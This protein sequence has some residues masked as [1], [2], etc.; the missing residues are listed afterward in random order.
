MSLNSFKDLENIQKHSILF[1][2]IEKH[3]KNIQMFK[4]CW[5]A[6]L[7]LQKVDILS[8]NA[9]IIL[10]SFL[11]LVYPLQRTNVPVRDSHSFS[12]YPSTIR[13]SSSNSGRWLREV[14]I[15]Y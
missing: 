15:V 10:V 12:I 4:I 7:G 11:Q 9:S 3:F 5:D 8:K 14:I 13:F 6:N 1:R 2:N